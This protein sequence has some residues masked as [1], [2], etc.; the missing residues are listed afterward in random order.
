MLRSIKNALRSK[1][2]QPSRGIK[3]GV[4]VRID[5]PNRISGHSS[6]VVGD[7]TSIGSDALISP[8][9]EYA[10]QRFSPTIVIG[11]DVYIGPHLYLA[12]I[13]RVV[14]GDGCVLS[15]W[16]YIN[17]CSHGL[18]P[19]AGLIMKQPLISGGDVEIGEGSFL[20]YRAVI[21][22]GVRL[23][24][25]CIVGINSVVTQSFPAYSMIVGSP[26]RLIKTWSPD[27]QSWLPVATPDV[28]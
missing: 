24:S 26:A 21:L 22:P 7:R 12:A 13:G 15:E 28:K 18:N 5:R 19:E 3:A 6:I 25:H 9:H 27:K 11:K 20:G 14:I 16:V 23:G 1:L 2:S 10:G 17:D 4:D 8:I